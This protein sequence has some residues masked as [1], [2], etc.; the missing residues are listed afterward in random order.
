MQIHWFHF[1]SRARTGSY[2][3]CG[4]ETPA[5]N[6]PNAKRTTLGCTMPS[7]ATRT[8]SGWLFGRYRSSFLWNIYMNIVLI[9][10]QIYIYIYITCIGDKQPKHTQLLQPCRY[11]P[12]TIST[13]ESNH[14]S[15]FGLLSEMHRR[16]V[17]AD[18]GLQM[19]ELEKKQSRQNC[20]KSGKPRYQPFGADSVLFFLLRCT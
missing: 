19:S 11:L 1:S 3:W 2:Q 5:V 10:S 9:Y 14:L 13:M 15:G 4:C 16:C 20:G 8:I 12:I 18:C 6:R 7:Y 17:A